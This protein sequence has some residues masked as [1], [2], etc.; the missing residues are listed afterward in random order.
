MRAARARMLCR[1]TSAPAGAGALEA[2]GAPA[3]GGRRLGKPSSFSASVR[4]FTIID[5]LIEGR[6]N[7]PASAHLAIDRMASHGLARSP[8]KSKRNNSSGALTTILVASRTSTEAHRLT[9]IIV[10]TTPS[11]FT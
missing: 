6:A 2:L 5:S 3:S 7:E 10:C 4:H 1:W 11:W 8:R 9:E